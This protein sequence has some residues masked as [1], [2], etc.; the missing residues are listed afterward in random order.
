MERVKEI[1]KIAEMKII[2]FNEDSAT[3]IV[4]FLRIWPSGRKIDSDPVLLDNG[5]LRVEWN[6]DDVRTGP[7]FMGN[8]NMQYVTLK[9][10]S[11][12]SKTSR[13]YGWGS[14]MDVIRRIEAFR[15]NSG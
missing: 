15:L 13:T 8:G 11:G 5:N 6:D 3:E 9:K 7:R 14:F 10:G 2:R 12:G 4:Y 1:R